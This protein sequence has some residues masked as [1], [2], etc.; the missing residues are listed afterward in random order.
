ML[1]CLTCTRLLRL[2]ITYVV[3]SLFF[4]IFVPVRVLVVPVLYFFFFVFSIFYMCTSCT[5]SILNK[6]HNIQTHLFI[7]IYQIHLQK[8]VLPLCYHYSSLLQSQHPQQRQAA[9]HPS[10]MVCSSSSSSSSSSGCSQSLEQSTHRPQDRD[11]FNG[12]FQTTLEDLAL[13]T[14]L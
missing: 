14:G 13:Q 7:F 4:Q 9:N 2:L 8:L 10:W 5:I 1:G 3:F 6:M 12:R 11:L